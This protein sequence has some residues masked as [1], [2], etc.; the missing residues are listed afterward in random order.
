M[1]TASGD[2][3]SGVPL[4]APPASRASG[5]QGIGVESGN[6]AGLRFNYNKCTV[7]LGVV[8]LVLLITVI[9]L[10]A[11]LPGR[12]PRV[13]GP[14]CPDDWVGYRGKCYHFS[15][16]ERN[17]TDSR[18]NCSALGASLAAIETLKEMAFMLRYSG[19]SDYW[20]GLCRARGQPWKW[21]NGT[22]FNSLFPIAGDDDCTYLD[23]NRINSLQCT[24]ERRWICNKPDVLTE[25]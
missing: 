12:S 19:S 25:A 16:A 24:S 13:P 9:A 8:S 17:W 2:A 3:E 23:G 10:A 7:A 15:E 11:S 5:Q 22:E 20:I 14:A 1:A 21:T 4:Q 18:S 6:G